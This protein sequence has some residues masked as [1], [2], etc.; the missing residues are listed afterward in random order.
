MP[1]FQAACREAEVPLFVADYTDRDRRAVFLCADH[2]AFHRAFFLRDHLTDK[3][4]RPQRI[5]RGRHRL[6]RRLRDGRRQAYDR[7]QEENSCSHG[8]LTQGDFLGTQLA[9]RFRQPQTSLKWHEEAVQIT[10]E[11][12][13][14]VTANK[15]YTPN[16]WPM[17]RGFRWVART[18][19]RRGGAVRFSRFSRILK[20]FE[21]S[22]IKKRARS[23]IAQKERAQN[24]IAP[25][26]RMAVLLA[27]D[28][29]ALQYNAVF[30]FMA[31]SV[32][33]TV[34]VPSTT[35]STPGAPGQGRA[36]AAFR[37]LR[38]RNFRL[39]F[40]GQ[41]IS[42]VGTWMQNVAQAWLIYRLT[43]SSV[44]LGVLGFVGQIPIFLLSP[45]AGLAADR[46]PRR[47]VVIA[48][49]TVSM[50]LAFSLAALTLSGH[51]GPERVKESSLE[52]IGLATLLGIVNAFDVPARQSFLIEMVGREDLLN[53]IALNSSMFNGARVAGPA[54]AG[55][56][57]AIVGEGWCFLLNGLSYLA[58]I[59]GLFMMR[60][61][62]LKPVH[63]GAA[64]LE[65][66]REGFR[67]AMQ[68]KPIRALLILVA[69]VSFMALP[70]SVLMPIF[71]VKIL[72]GGASAYG[73]LMGAVGFGAMFGALV[74]AM[75]QE[76]RGLGNV[77]A[78]AATG[79]GFSLVLFSAS[80]W[81]MLSFVILLFSGFAMMMQFT[82]TN[83]LI[84]AMVPDQLRGRVM[85]M[86]AMMFL[87]MT[88]IGS[89]FAGLLAD[90]IGA[91]VTVAIGGLV[92]CLGGLIFARKWPALR[93]P[94][95][96]L[97]AAQGMM[98]TPS[99]TTPPAPPS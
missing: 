18:V 8:S 64:P 39:F 43:G 15:Q 58:V 28:A 72:H 80:H 62:N 31:D 20:S 52:I 71:A 79:L 78:F 67:F 76:L 12:P 4:R 45:L 23:R 53:A 22:P 63:D 85:S 11:C 5:C 86:Y 46:W 73:W 25:P 91:P 48:T 1:R 66:L 38:H 13:F 95:R 88:P 34:E 32:P 68:T 69:V 14:D 82:A 54:I 26:R 84:Q 33:T 44:L 55:A 98:P 99:R 81:F 50:L 36:A 97:V 35:T 74:L 2:D 10:P 57:V 21:L 94:A 3:S 83:T 60:I 77:V 70:F 56:L 16:Q 89:L 90:H 42:L 17:E 49:Q 93:G 19:I 27:D 75:R 40:G 30:R 96:D 65:K 37:A 9:E 59:A 41:I 7:D 47:R 29:D 6:W 51:I 87:G 92:S 61:E 24:R